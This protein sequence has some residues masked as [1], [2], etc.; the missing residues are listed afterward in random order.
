LRVCFLIAFGTVPS[1]LLLAVAA[2]APAIAAAELVT[3]FVFAFGGVLW[4]TTLQEHVPAEARSRVSSY[5]WMG[6]TA[7]RPVGLAVAGSV[8]AAFGVK[9]TLLGAAAIVLGASLAI[10]SVPGVRDLER[11]EPDRLPPGIVPSAD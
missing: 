8:A 3:G 4:E 5:D 2:P 11:R 9:E 7:L 1:L 6:S 10:L